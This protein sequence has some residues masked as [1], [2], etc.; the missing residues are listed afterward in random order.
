MEGGTY[1]R[2]KDGTLKLVEPATADHADGNQARAAN[3]G[4]APTVEPP[5]PKTTT[6]GGDK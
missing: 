3:E 6:K 1:I 5:T 2:Q 4:P